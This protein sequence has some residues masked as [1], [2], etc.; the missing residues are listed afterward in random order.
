[1]LVSIWLN[2]IFINF[3]FEYLTTCDMHIV[4]QFLFKELLTN[5]LDLGNPIV[6]IDVTSFFS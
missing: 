5:A 4:R 6:K 1:M 3:L 2:V